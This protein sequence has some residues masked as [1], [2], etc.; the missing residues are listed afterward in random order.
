MMIKMLDG[1]YCGKWWIAAE[2]AKERAISGKEEITIVRDGNHW[3]VQPNWFNRKSDDIVPDSAA[4]VDTTTYG[5]QP[6]DGETL[7]D[8]WDQFG[9]DADQ[10]D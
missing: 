2:L 8:G 3:V 7:Q 10:I 6:F 1:T 9:P 5:L 4:P